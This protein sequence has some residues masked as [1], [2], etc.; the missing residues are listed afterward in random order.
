MPNF[1]LIEKASSNACVG[2]SWAPSPAFTILADTF[3][4]RKKISKPDYL[5]ID[6]KDLNKQTSKIKALLRQNNFSSE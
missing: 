3:F 4:E 2:C 1:S 5:K 6:L